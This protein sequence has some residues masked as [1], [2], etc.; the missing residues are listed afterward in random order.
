MGKDKTA[1]YLRFGL[2]AV[3]SILVILGVIFIFIKKFRDEKK[4]R[5]LQERYNNVHTVA[6]KR[7]DN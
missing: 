6:F 7:E 3:P 1:E 5:K 2:I 4:K